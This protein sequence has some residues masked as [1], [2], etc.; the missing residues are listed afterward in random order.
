MFSPKSCYTYYY[1][2]H[3]LDEGNFLMTKD[4]TR[5]EEW[6]YLLENQKNQMDIDDFEKSKKHSGHSSGTRG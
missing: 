6:Y 4:E 1:L 2:P 3:H 5:D